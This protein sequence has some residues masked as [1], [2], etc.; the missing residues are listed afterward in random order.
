MPVPTQLKGTLNAVNDK[1]DS[2]SREYEITVREKAALEYHSNEQSA[3]LKSM[4]EER[5]KEVE[6]LKH[7]VKTPKYVIYSTS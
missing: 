7:Q 3:K 6:A 5:I 1:H 2:L 4:L